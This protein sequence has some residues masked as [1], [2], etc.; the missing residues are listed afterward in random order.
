MN[1]VGLRDTDMLIYFHG[2]VGKLS[3]PQHEDIYVTMFW[4]ASNADMQTELNFYDDWYRHWPFNKFKK[5]YVSIDCFFR[6]SIQ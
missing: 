4:A 5:I 6:I 2:S 1:T 3:Y